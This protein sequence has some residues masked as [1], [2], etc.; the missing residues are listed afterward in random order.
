MKFRTGIPYGFILR[1]LVSL[2]LGLVDSLIIDVRI[3]GAA[4]RHIASLAV[5]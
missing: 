1:S 2:V 4:R 5:G 3:E